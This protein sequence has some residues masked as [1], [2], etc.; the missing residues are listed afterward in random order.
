MNNH[1]DGFK[2]FSATKH[3]ERS[4]LG[5]R[6]TEWLQVSQAEIVQVWV[7]QSSDNEFHCL[8]ITIAYREKR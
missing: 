3:M 1:I 6:V 4:S 7:N 2:V 5:D 8:S